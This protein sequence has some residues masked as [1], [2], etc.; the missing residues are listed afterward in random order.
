[1]KISKSSHENQRVK[2]SMILVTIM[3]SVW[4]TCENEA[5]ILLHMAYY[6]IFKIDSSIIT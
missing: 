2:R 5:W 6:K 1:M 3:Q 4:E